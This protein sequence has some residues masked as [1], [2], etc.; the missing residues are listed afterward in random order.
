[1][2]VPYRSRY[3]GARVRLSYLIMI[4]H[5]HIYEAQYYTYLSICS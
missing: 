5:M 4:M 2:A 1:M 3:R